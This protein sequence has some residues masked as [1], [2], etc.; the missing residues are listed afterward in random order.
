[1]RRMKR[2]LA[3]FVRW[4]RT[5]AVVQARLGS[6]RFPGKVL[7]I[8]PDGRPMVAHVVERVLSSSAIDQVALAFPYGEGRIYRECMNCID[9]ELRSKVFSLEGPAL[10]VLNRFCLAIDVCEPDVVVRVTADCPFFDPFVVKPLVDM[11]W[12]RGFVYAS[13]T[14]PGVDGLDCEALD[15]REFRKWAEEFSRDRT[16]SWDAVVYTRE[17]V[18]PLF[19]CRP[20]H[21][22]GHYSYMLEHSGSKWSVDTR[23]DFDKACRVC[24]V[25]MEKRFSSDMPEDATSFHFLTTLRAYSF[26]KD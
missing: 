5:L 19:R 6:A 1:M 22:L 21:E 18:T 23:E 24:A 25:L 15:G 2:R 3:S 7:E 8:F 10:N 16:L 12:K 13:N 26:I 9:R 20:S 17:H 4:P 11:V 14:H